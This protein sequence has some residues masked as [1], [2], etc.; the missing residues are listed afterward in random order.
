MQVVVYLGDFIVVYCISF[1]KVKLIVTDHRNRLNV[2]TTN[3]LLMVG[4]N[5]SSVK[6][7]DIE[8]VVDLYLSEKSRKLC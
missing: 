1:S 8:K 2:A 4:I 3:K 5:T 6:D 7:L